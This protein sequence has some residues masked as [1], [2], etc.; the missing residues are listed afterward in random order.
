MKRR[1]KPLIDTVGRDATA[2]QRVTFT[3]ELPAYR[4][5]LGTPVGNMLAK[6][7]S[8]NIRLAKAWCTKRAK[9]FGVSLSSAFPA[10]SYELLGKAAFDLDSPINQRFSVF[11]GYRSWDASEREA[12]GE[13]KQLGDQSVAKS[14]QSGALESGG[15][16]GVKA[17]LTRFFWRV[18]GTE[19]FVFDRAENPG[20][21][22]RRSLKQAK[23]VERARDAAGRFTPSKERGVS[24][25]VK[26]RQWVKV[27][28]MPRKGSNLSDLYDAFPDYSQSSIRR[29]LAK[30]RRK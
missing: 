6:A 10:A 8:S 30:L 12:R 29:E 18:L 11:N 26:L 4:F 17:K 23:T 3:F 1:L 5:R 2:R 20:R 9:E 14:I 24:L 13:A 28:G 22:S 25:A 7:V 27:Y 15:S 19:G 16:R 21:I